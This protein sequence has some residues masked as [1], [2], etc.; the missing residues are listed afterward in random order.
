MRSIKCTLKQEEKVERADTK[1]GTLGMFLKDQIGNIYFTT[2]SHVTR[3][4]EIALGEGGLELG[5]RSK[6][7]IPQFLHF[8]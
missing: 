6:V 2:C 1:F 5:Q 4:D 7:Q 3:M 8:L